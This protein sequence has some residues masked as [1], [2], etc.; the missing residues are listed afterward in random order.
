MTTH[1]A[2]SSRLEMSFAGFS[3]AQ[4]FPRADRDP[5]LGLVGH[6]RKLEGVGGAVN[7]L[8][9]DARFGDAHGE[10][11]CDDDDSSYLSKRK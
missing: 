10:G 1:R 5:S 9:S 3:D 11:F 2:I 4:A 6:D 8:G 7:E